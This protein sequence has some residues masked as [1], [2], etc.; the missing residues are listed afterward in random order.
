MAGFFKKPWSV[1]MVSILR[2]ECVTRMCVPL[3]SQRSSCISV[4]FVARDERS[5]CVA[6]PASRSERDPPAR[7]ILSE[8]QDAPTAKRTRRRIQHDASLNRTDPQFPPRATGN[9]NTRGF[10]VVATVV[11]K[12]MR[13]PCT[14]IHLAIAFQIYFRFWT[15]RERHPA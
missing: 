14:P 6:E 12:R 9:N 7:S 8:G 5:A 11:A 10:F 15:D 2:N 3:S 4:W 1:T 13:V